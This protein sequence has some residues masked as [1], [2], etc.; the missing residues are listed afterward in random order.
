MNAEINKPNKILNG[1]AL[2]YKRSGFD[3]VNLLIR[4]GKNMLTGARGILSKLSFSFDT[5]CSIIF[6]KFT[7]SVAKPIFKILGQKT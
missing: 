4:T 2:M 7:L 1:M 5:P 3:F 6:R